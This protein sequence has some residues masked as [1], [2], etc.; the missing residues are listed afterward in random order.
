MG[1][2]TDVGRTRDHNEDHYI[3]DPQ[4]GLFVVCDGMGGHAAGEVASAIAVDAIA[5]RMRRGHDL[6]V[7]MQTAHQAVIDASHDG[8]G[9][10]GMGT[11]AVALH[12]QGSEYQIAWV[13][14][15]RAYLWD[16]GVRPLTR[17]HTFV[18]ELVDSGALT[19]AEA[20][21][22]PDRSIITQALGAADITEVTVDEIRGQLYHGQK[23]L[24]CSDGLTCELTDHQIGSIISA[25]GSNQE[26]VETLIHAANTKGGEDNITAILVSSP[27]D[28]PIKSRNGY[29]KRRYTATLNEM[30]EGKNELKRSSGIVLGVLILVVACLLTYFLILESGFWL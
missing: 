20:S 19:E 7:A 12:I 26:I 24:L 27:E 14:D 17:D 30:P 2:A 18:Q 23:V 8:R 25:E 3:A 6:V 4:H 5:D 1:H 13:G 9:Q 21:N 10:P 28:S 22:H 11:T 15:S 29:A 16:D